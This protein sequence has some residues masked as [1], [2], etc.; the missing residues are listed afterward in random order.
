MSAWRA[1]GLILALLCLS[2]LPG[3]YLLDLLF[4]P[5]A[6]GSGFI[7]D[8]AGYILTNEHVVHGA[9]AIEVFLGERAYSAEVLAADEQEDLALLKI[10]AAGLPVVF[11]ADSTKVELL[12]H[13]VAMGFPEPGFGRDLTVAE[14][15]I[16]SIRTNVPGREG[17]ETFQTDAAIYHGSSGGPL[18]NLKGEVL[19]VN[20]AGLEGSE[21]YFAIPINDAIPLLERVP[22]FHRE[23]MGRQTEI[24][25]PAEIVARYRA[26]V[27]YIEATI[28]QSLSP[29]R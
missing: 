27:V 26:A 24:L 14:G 21:F 4:P 6:A 16:T 20:Y 19:G 23:E 17:K 11:L 3:C 5:K 22:G 18:F 2:L 12:E 29:F 7:V 10:P 13:V 8:S 1:G 25:T 9:L 15:Q 28:D